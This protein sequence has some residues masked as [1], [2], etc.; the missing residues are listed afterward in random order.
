MRGSE[1]RKSL[2]SGLSLSINYSLNYSPNCKLSCGGLTLIE[3]LMTLLI[4]AMLLSLGIPGMKH[5]AQQKA[6]EVTIKRLHRAIE[7]ARTSAITRNSIVTLCRS[8]DGAVCGGEWQQGVL[9]FSD[10]NGNRELELEDS[11]I[12]YFQ[13]PEF[14][15]QIFWRAF[16]NR[17]YL[18]ITPLG[19][20]RYQNGNFTVC[21]DNGGLQNA[22]QIILNRAGRVRYAMDVDGD[23]IRED[24]GGKPLKCS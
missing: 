11:L 20:T 13:F 6:S 9:V 18:Q 3:L 24:S 4:L 23:G 19:S 12:R 1:Q 15:G 8:G 10:Y 14:S 5:L 2:N 16:Q 7:V 21:P 17:Q 22:Q